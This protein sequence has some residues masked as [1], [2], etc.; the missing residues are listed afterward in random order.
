M[1]A[2]YQDRCGLGPLLVA[3]SETPE[4]LLMF[5]GIVFG[6]D[7]EAPRLLVE[8]RRHPPRSLQERANCFVRDRAIFE[9]TRAEALL[10]EHVN[11][12]I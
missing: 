7:E 11:R 6:R 4:K 9:S 8:R 10:Q 2:M 3:G 5:C 12:F 1:L